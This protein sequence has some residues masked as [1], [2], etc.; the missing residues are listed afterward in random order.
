MHGPFMRL[1]WKEYRSQRNL[2][3]ALYSFA[4]C[5]T[6]IVAYF[7]E[8]RDRPFGSMLTITAFVGL[9][10]TICSLLYLFAGEEDN[11]TA[12]WLRHLPMKT[13]TLLLAKLTTTVI[14]TLL[15]LLISALS[16]VLIYA[17]ACQFRHQPLLHNWIPGEY[18]G[19][20]S[21]S[22]KSINDLIKIASVIV[23]CLSL[24]LFW[25][26]YCR[27][28]VAAICGC[29]VSLIGFPLLLTLNSAEPFERGSVLDPFVWWVL[30]TLSLSF[31]LSMYMLPGWHRG[32][33]RLDVVNLWT[34]FRNRF[35]V[36]SRESGA[37]FLATRLQ[38]SALRSPLISRTRG[39]LL[40]QQLRAAIP[41]AAIA[42]LLTIPAVWIRYHHNV[43]IPLILT[44]FIAVECGLRTFRDDQRKGSGLFWAHRGVSPTAVL[45]TRHTV[46]LSVA[47]VLFVG[48]MFCE[49]CAGTATPQEL[50][51]IEV[52]NVIGLPF[53][54]FSQE[55]ISSVFGYRLSI[56][57]AW[58]VGG[59]AIGHLSSVMIRKAF[60]A[61]FISL[62][63]FL[64]YTILLGSILVMDVSP[65]LTVWPLALSFLLMPM[66]TRR[67]WMDHH[68]ESWKHDLRH[69]LLFAVP[70]LCMWPM[71]QIGRLWLPLQL[72]KGSSAE[73]RNGVTVSLDRRSSRNLKTWNAAWEQLALHVQAAPIN[74]NV[75][76]RPL[77][78]KT[79]TRQQH[80]RAIHSVDEI[81]K[82]LFGAV[83]TYRLPL[84]YQ[85]PWSVSFAEPVASL[86]V[87]EAGY[88]RDDGE[89]QRCLERL[90]Q[91]KR[92]LTYLAEES[93][94]RNQL[95]TCMIWHQIIDQHIHDAIADDRVTSAVLDNFQLAFADNC[96]GPR[97]SSW[98]HEH[99]LAAWYGLHLANTDIESLPPL[100][101][102]FKQ[103][104]WVERVRFLAII[105][106]A[107]RIE[108]LG[109]DWPEAMRLFKNASRALK[110]VVHPELKHY[111]DLI[112]HFPSTHSSGDPVFG[113]P[114]FPAINS[115]RATRLIIAMQRSRRE[116]GE[117][118]QQ[119]TELNSGPKSQLPI[120]VRNDGAMFQYSMNGLGRKFKID[121][122]ISRAFA[123][124]FATIP[125][126]KQPLLWIS[127]RMGPALKLD[128]FD[129]GVSTE[130]ALPLNPNRIIYFDGTRR[131]FFPINRLWGG[132]PEDTYSEVIKEPSAEEMQ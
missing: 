56:A 114:G 110:T 72:S 50:S 75:V 66:A 1:V 59:Y 46:W 30:S 124:A 40:W 37:G 33:R 64:G 48:C 122:G 35:A 2:W 54:E 95:E 129:E 83:V 18:P 128:T 34:R 55:T 39:V 8:T 130:I 118:P 103:S 79:R 70:V 74:N 104:M 19:R 68:S 5:L 6:V 106:A 49:W 100:P 17:V 10:T 43:P 65:W 78:I 91:A 22:R 23:A 29:G 88:L 52:W 117:F 76:P 80:E 113:D 67:Y 38:K 26:L 31:G 25:S 3:L 101:K 4:M 126:S 81:A 119:L 24:T 44:G 90:V 61:A 73:L 42:L 109:H 93:S 45:I 69:I 62:L 77:A 71:Y 15:F 28:M 108:Q 94:D 127:G 125:D 57:M 86:L 131:V 98:M 12:P 13:R 58:L 7:A 63:C 97:Q 85:Q 111:L 82:T 112:L 36:R 60:V 116:H 102:A 120:F 123:V 53:R 47:V 115:H 92:F 14:A 21:L 27:K 107:T 16:V 105:D 9:T 41:F 96:I 84:Q 132:E 51:M 87:Q 20:A 89:F 121:S 32:I 99:R 11:G